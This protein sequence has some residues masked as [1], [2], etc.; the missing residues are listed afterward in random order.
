MTCQENQKL[1][2]IIETDGIQKLKR[3]ENV[4]LKLRIKKVCQSEA[5]CLQ[6]KKREIS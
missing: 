5:N 1:R 6:M 3:I 2:K 4:E